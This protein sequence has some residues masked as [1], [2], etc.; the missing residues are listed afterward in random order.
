[1]LDSKE[2]IVRTENAVFEVLLDQ[3]SGL[4]TSFYPGEVP[5]DESKVELLYPA[6]D[7]PSP[8]KQHIRVFVSNTAKNH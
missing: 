5:N 6:R 4:T 1:M 8:G 2:T 3:R 7:L